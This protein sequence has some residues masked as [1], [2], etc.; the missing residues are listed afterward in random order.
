MSTEATFGD[1][2]QEAESENQNAGPL[3]AGERI[4]VRLTVTTIDESNGNLSFTFKGTD[5]GDAAKG[6]AP[7]L[8]Q[9]TK[10]FWANNF[11]SKDEKYNLD[12]VKRQMGQIKHIL[13]AYLTE[14]ELASIRPTSWAAFTSQVS[15]M[16]N[17]KKTEEIPAFIKGIY[18]N[19]DYV[20]FPMFPDFISTD[21][22][23]KNLRLNTK[24]NPKTGNPY[25]RITKLE[26]TPATADAT[27]G[28][29]D[30][31]PAPAYGAMNDDE[32][33]I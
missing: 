29:D 22:K 10:T 5:K 31:V 4:A 19:K 21:L 23:P 13:G 14:E 3:T 28:S 18:N 32:C 33:P 24:T 9:F 6:I 8:G 16:M 17:G 26:A 15:K 27:P 12:S 30:E 11:D 7:N 20:D 25:E 2:F 1:L